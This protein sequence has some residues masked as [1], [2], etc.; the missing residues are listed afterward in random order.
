MNK[1]FWVSV[2]VMFVMFMGI[3][4]FVHGF[5]LQADY[6]QLPNLFRSA[7]DQMNFVVFMPVADLFAA[8]AVVW[9]YVRIKDDKPFLTQGICYGLA[10]T[11]IMTIPKFLIYYAVQ[12]I[13]GITVAKQ[14]AFD[15]M[16]DVLK[17]IAV[18]RLN[19]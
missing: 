14:I 15:V 7:Q 2:A 16:G 6:K 17:G 8:F 11:A 5:L 4:F 3:G 9:I 13:P 19:R 18:A 12:P 10:I 1:R